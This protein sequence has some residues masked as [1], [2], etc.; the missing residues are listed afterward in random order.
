MFLLE[1]KR[2]RRVKERKSLFGVATSSKE[3]AKKTA[4]VARALSHRNRSGGRGG[5]AWHSRVGGRV[6]QR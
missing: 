4:L 1:E 2:A 3:C 5:N 6:A